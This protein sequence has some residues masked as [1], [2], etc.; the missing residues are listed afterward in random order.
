MQGLATMK[1]VGIAKL[2]QC[3]LVVVPEMQG[4]GRDDIRM[5]VFVLMEGFTC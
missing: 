3:S 5:P 2:Q 4:P 1:A